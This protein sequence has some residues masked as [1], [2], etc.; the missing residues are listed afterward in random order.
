MP[1]QLE[2]E[3]WVPFPIERVFAFFS[4][5]ENLPRIMPASSH[6]KLS[7]LNRMPTPSPP[8]GLA[9]E[10]AAGVGS[11]IVTS[12]RVFP[13]MPV[14]AKWIARITEFEWNHCFADVHDRGRF[15][16]WHHRHEFQAET[17][18]GVTGTLVRDVIEYEVGSG[19]LGTIANAIFVRRQM[20][21][22]FAQREQVLPKL[23]SQLT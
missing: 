16:S 15:K 20:Q 9:A 2:F 11:T 5:P 19:F 14:R 23:L 1:H 18:D 13:F 6:T 4:N 21:S 12:F 7:V 8:P 17:R 22:T 3:Q 10:K